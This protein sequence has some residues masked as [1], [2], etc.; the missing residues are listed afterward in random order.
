[1]GVDRSRM[2]HPSLQPAVAAALRAALARLDQ[3]FSVTDVDGAALTEIAGTFDDV[4]LWEAW[5]V[6][7]DQVEGHPERYGPETLRLLR[8]ASA[9]NEDAHQAPLPPRTRLHPRPAQGYAGL[10]VLI[11]P[12]AP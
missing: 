4:L 7:R 2:E 8:A 9:V 11:T 12:A 6:H 3:A 10:H 5:Q 1:V